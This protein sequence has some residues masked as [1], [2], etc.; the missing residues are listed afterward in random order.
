MRSAPYYQDEVATLYGCDMMKVL[1][2]LPPG[3]V[4]AVITDPPYSSGGRTAGERR[5]S[6][7]EKYMGTEAKQNSEGRL[8]DFAGDERDQRSYLRWMNL[9]MSDVVPALSN[10][11]IVM[12]FAD[13]RQLPLVT[14]AVQVAGISWRGI[15][16][17]YKSN[18]RRQQG[19]F[20]NSCEYVVWGT[21]GAVVPLDVP[22]QPGLLN[23][24]NVFYRDR[25]HVTQKPLG[26]MRQL[27]KATRPGGT[28]LDP[29]M[30]SG[31]TGVAALS[32]GR[33]FIG[34]EI[35]SEYQTVAED[36]IR[37]ARNDQAN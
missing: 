25:V 28:V 9:W 10:G 26:I 12:L 30:G 36:R 14:D 13:W 1:E 34:C 21:K 17:W 27:V 6:T 20:A 4:D 33:R 31:T 24:P 23:E 22:S 32:E 15:I 29:F 16:P 3:S 5:R 37:Q 7:K 2:G 35:V 19:K 8:V 11:G 18:S